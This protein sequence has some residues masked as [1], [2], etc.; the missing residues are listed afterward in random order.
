VGLSADKP[1]ALAAAHE[2]WVDDYRIN[3]WETDARRRAPAPH[4]C[5]L[6]QETAWGHA[7]HLRMG[8]RDFARQGLAWVLSRFTMR[9][10]RRPRWRETLRVHTS[11]PAR[12]K[13]YF[14]RDFFLTD[15]DGGEL[16]RASSLWF[17]ID[18]AR[19]RPRRTASYAGHVVVTEYA[20]LLGTPEKLEPPAAGE[21]AATFRVR[22]H[23]LDL[24][25]HLTSSRYLDW[26]LDSFPG[27]LHRDHE[28]RGLTVNYL[29]EALL[30]EE[31]RVITADLGAGR[32]LSVLKK[33][34]AGPDA[35]VVR[36][37]WG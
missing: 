7:E 16:A 30:D 11:V 21:P 31:L 34:P 2:V 35:C 19:R 15:A 3:S 36:T 29:A 37:E 1:A 28:L 4:L 27:E 25:G 5:R 20:D 24:N 13:L 8:T 6:M 18:A 10:V 26:V 33:T 23:D 14:H 22:Y 9:L 12:E 17:A 32:Y